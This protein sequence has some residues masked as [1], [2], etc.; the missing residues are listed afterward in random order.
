[1]EMIVIVI[2]SMETDGVMS[3]DCE[4]YVSIFLIYLFIRLG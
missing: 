1:M 4:L 2:C 3:E